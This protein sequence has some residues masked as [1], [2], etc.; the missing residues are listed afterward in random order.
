MLILGLAGVNRRLYDG[1]LQYALA[2]PHH[3]LQVGMSYAA[4]SLALFQVPFIWNVFASLKFGRVV[5]ANPWQATTLEWA[6]APTP[7]IAHGNFETVPA[8]YRPP[9][10]YSVPGAAE[11][12]V[13]QNST[14][15]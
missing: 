13:P 1:G 4:W 12:F 2:Q 10:E 9:Y 5:D 8:V 6:A 15:V 11:D 7:P 3:N 14:S